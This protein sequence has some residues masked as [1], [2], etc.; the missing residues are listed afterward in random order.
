[1]Q[2]YQRIAELTV[3]GFT[4]H[5]RKTWDKVI[6]V[7]LSGHGYTHYDLLNIDAFYLV[8]FDPIL[9]S[10]DKMYN[11]HLKLTQCNNSK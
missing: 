10:I 9:K 3:S 8:D 7:Q 1:M 5:T 11:R 2:L 6:K 4:I